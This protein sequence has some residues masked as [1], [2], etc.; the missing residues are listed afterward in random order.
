MNG[1]KAALVRLL[2]RLC[3]LLPLRVARAMGRGVASLYW[4]L[5]GASRRVTQRNIDLAFPRLSPTDRRDL[6]RRSLLATA[7]LA[8][9]TGHV[10]L[11]SWKHVERL[12]ESVDGDELLRAAR[13]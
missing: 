10:W 13:A 12:I 11:R 6:A 7:E 2:L 5:G 3:A 8:A 4:P 9:E 1:F